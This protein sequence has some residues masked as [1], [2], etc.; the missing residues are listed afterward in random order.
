MYREKDLIKQA[1][2]YTT[3]NSRYSNNFIDNKSYADIAVGQ[4]RNH[5]INAHLRYL[6]TADGMGN[7][8]QLILSNETPDMAKSF[9]PNTRLVSIMF[10]STGKPSQKSRIP[11]KR[12]NTEFNTKRP[13]SEINRASLDITKLSLI[14]NFKNWFRHDAN[15]IHNS[16]LNT[17]M[18][19]KRA[20]KNITGVEL[21]E[22]QETAAEIQF[23]NGNYPGEL[24]I[25]D[26]QDNPEQLK[27]FLKAFA[28]L[29]IK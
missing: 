21:G 8:N 13:A 2:F 9:S 7:K 16:T 4:R 6:K 24:R 25:E 23:P 19:Q 27:T 15:A 28:S 22:P 10:N 1:T 5:G 3:K 12:S 11:P 14:N 29:S 20:R 17:K 26:A 18:L